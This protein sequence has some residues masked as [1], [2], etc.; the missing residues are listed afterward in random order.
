MENFTRFALWW[1]LT[2]GFK[3]GLGIYNIIKSKRHSFKWNGVKK[4]VYYEQV[5][6]F[7]FPSDF[8]VKL[9]HKEASLFSLLG[10]L[11]GAKKFIPLT[12]KLF[13]EKAKTIFFTFRNKKCKALQSISKASR[14][15]L[16]NFFFYRKPLENLFRCEKRRRQRFIWWNDKQID[17]RFAATGKLSR[18]RNRKTHIGTPDWHGKQYALFIFLYSFFIDCFAAQIS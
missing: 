17:Q 8:E 14:L 18:E 6:I 5:S 13:I 1:L 11:R 16:I 15:Q 3:S 7:S 10:I 4:C 12:T 9:K 2:M